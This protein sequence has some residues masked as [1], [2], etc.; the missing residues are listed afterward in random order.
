MWRGPP[1]RLRRQSPSGRSPGSPARTDAPGRS[2]SLRPAGPRSAGY[3]SVPPAL[4]DLPEEGRRALVAVADRVGGDRVEA[5][6]AGLQLRGGEGCRAGHVRLAVVA[7]GEGGGGRGGGDG[8]A[9]LAALGLRLWMRAD[10]GIR[11][12]R[13]NRERVGG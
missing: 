6:L 13:V 7:A 1:R 3:R 4:L 2:P 10:R 5:V 11:R 12:G 9:G 8:E